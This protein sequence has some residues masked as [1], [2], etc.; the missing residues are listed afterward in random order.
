MAIQ[1]SL[2]TGLPAGINSLIQEGLLERAFH[3]GLYPTILYRNEA[4]WQ[5]FEGNLGTE[6]LFTRP[7]LLKPTTTPNSAG[8]D[9]TPMANTF[10]QWFGRID[11]YSGSI[12]TLMTSS[13]V[14]MS[15]LFM[16]NVHQLG[17]HAAQ[18][19]NR[20]ARNNMFKAYLGGS[21]NLIAA[22]ANLDTLIHVAAL[23]GFTTVVGQVASQVRPV[24]VS[25]SNPLPITIRAAGGDQVRNVIGFTPDD[26]ADPFGPGFLL[27]SAGVSGVIATRT[28][29]LAKDRGVIIRAGGGDSVDALSSADTMTLQDIINAAGQ[30]RQRSVPPHEDGL[31]HA[32]VSPIVNTQLFADPVWQ[33]LHQSLPK[34]D[35]YQTGFIGVMSG[36]GF[37][38]NNE[39]PDSTNSGT[40]VNTGTPETYAG[41]IGAEVVNH[42]GIQVGR[43]IVTGKGVMYELGLDESAYVT[44]AGV[45]GKIGEFDIVNAGAA[46]STERIRLVI[47]APLDRMQ[48][49]VAAT[50]SI[51]AGWALP[52]DI[53]GPGGTERYKRAVVIESAAG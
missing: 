16:R 7:G 20:V 36:V 31:Y 51:T 18:S 25:S 6:I 11:Q 45:T 12:D 37:Y 50:W 43:V 46:V 42:G 47:R 23:N 44:E 29:V 48:Q 10:E 22:T 14:A 15:D 49:L 9:P 52:T 26:P 38:L 24:P 39:S 21:T 5:R 32:H 28:P 1:P 30:L 3:D 4:N 40:L 53:T 35:V 19:I 13:A 41:D 33:R 17:L 2:S 27:L 34:D 8:A